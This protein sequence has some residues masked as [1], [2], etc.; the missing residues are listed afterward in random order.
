MADR[1]IQLESVKQLRRILSLRRDPPITPVV[2]T[3]VVT[4]LLELALAPI[5]SAVAEIHAA[6]VTEESSRV[7][8]TVEKGPL[9]VKYDDLQFE[10]I[11]C[12]MNVAS[13]STENVEAVVKEGMS[14]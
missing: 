10:A 9:R 5:V 1:D 8:P 14:I 13:G 4:R 6:Q 11:W 12:L 7:L 2:A 3:G